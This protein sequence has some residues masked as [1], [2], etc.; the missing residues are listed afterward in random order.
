MAVSRLEVSGVS[1]PTRGEQRPQLLVLRRSGKT[2]AAHQDIDRATAITTR[3]GSFMKTREITPR[4]YLCIVGAC[5]AAFATDRDTVLLVGKLVKDPS[6][7]GVHPERLTSE[8]AMIEVPVGFLS[9]LFGDKGS[10]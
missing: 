8:E 5:P 1:P 2:H 10:K 7:V 9:A 4:E 3:K 6:A